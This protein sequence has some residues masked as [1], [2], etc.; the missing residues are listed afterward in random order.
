MDVTRGGAAGWTGRGPEGASVT[1]TQADAVPA[2]GEGD[3]D[4]CVGVT[5]GSENVMSVRLIPERFTS[6][7]RQQHL[8]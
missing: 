4:G 8:D 3:F 1:P 6:T 2:I 5:G 7:L